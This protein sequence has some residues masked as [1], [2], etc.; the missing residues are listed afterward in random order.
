MFFCPSFFGGGVLG[1]RVLIG[2]GKRGI[3]QGLTRVVARVSYVSRQVLVLVAVTR[4]EYS[5]L[6]HSSQ[7]RQVFCCIRFTH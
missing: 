3:D 6:L 4:D 7:E 5:I 2:L 1:L